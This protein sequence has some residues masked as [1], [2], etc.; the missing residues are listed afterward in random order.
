MMANMKILTVSQ[1]NAFAKSI[2]DSDSL[3]SNVFLTGEISNFKN[4]YQS[5]HMYFSLKDEKAT[6][7]AVMF[8]YSAKN[9]KFLPQDGMNVIV[10][11]RVSIYEVTGTYQIYVED[12]QPDGIGSLNLAFEQLKSKLEKEGLFNVENKKSLP[13]YPKKVGVITAKTGAVFFDI[14]NVLKRRFPLIEILFYPVL[15]QG[16][17]APFEI[18][19][20]IN[21]MNDFTDADVLIV[22]RGGG[23]IEDLWAFND[24]KLARTIYASRIPIVSAV[25]HE[26]DFTICDFVADLRAPTPSAA[27]E[28]VSQDSQKLLEDLLKKFNYMAELLKLKLSY[29]GN[30]FKRL[31]KNEVIYKPISLIIKKNLQLDLLE[32]KLLLN[33]S[34]IVNQSKGEFLSLVS[35]MDAL[36]PLK[37]L[38]AGY[39]IVT[40]EKDNIIRS[41]KDVKNNDKINVKLKDGSLSCLVCDVNCDDLEE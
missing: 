37:L 36:S 8:S 33:F 41:I 6:I 31:E 35:K 30:H 24:E 21:Y 23:S 10:R 7:K 32:N 34:N 19:E 16:K 20:A 27:A 29:C 4:H 5:G 13:K 26:T 25:G 2:V 40:T 28:L 17:D 9:L 1:L 15:V 39:G 12:M 22:G 14:Q 18:I 38:N 3:L 11:G